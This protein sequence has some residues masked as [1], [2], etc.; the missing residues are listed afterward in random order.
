[1][2]QLLDPEKSR[3]VKELKHKSPL[4]GCRFDAAGRFVFAGA[5]DNTVQRW[6]I[7]TD[8]R[9]ALNGHSSW[10]RGI[11]S[12][13]EG[14]MVFT[15][16]YDGHLKSWASAAEQP[17]AVW[18]QLAHKGW[19]RAVA[20]S[21]CGRWIASAGNDHTVRI[22]SITDCSL[23]RELVGHSS[24]VYNAAFHPDGR[25]L[26]S[27]DLKGEVIHWEFDTGSLV[28]RL[29]AT[30]LCKY[31]TSFKADCGG[32]RS[33]AF[34]PDGRFLGCAGITDVTNAFAGI[35]KPV[36]VLFDWISGGR[37]ELLRPN[38]EFT[39][40][41]WGVAF[42]SSGMIIGVGGGASGGA[43]WFWRPGFAQAFSSL[44]LPSQARD[45]DLHP[46]GVRLAVAHFDGA[47]RIIDMSH[48][49]S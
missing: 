2:S 16:S 28:R 25:H 21:P 33:M 32:V 47:V 27:A 24:H 30:V 40:V 34:S 36:I 12:S 13:P 45:L 7:A 23:A 15:G 39:G 8:Q 43:V 31:D 11:A 41:M 46:D 44:K 35:G 3:I 29:D 49:P 48:K 10:V 1:V 18:T 22:W 38:Q 17:A 19:V 14:E 9:A 4:L 6:D 5:Q 26:V 20:I 42:H 37:K